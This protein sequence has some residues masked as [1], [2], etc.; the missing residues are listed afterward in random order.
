MVLREAEVVYRGRRV[1]GPG[2]VRCAA[3]VARIC[4]DVEAATV[5]RFMVLHLNQRHAVVARHVVSQGSLGCVEVHPREV[6]RAAI[7]AGAAA[8][9]LVHNHPSGDCAPSPEDWSVTKRICAAGELLGIRVLDHVVIG[10]GS[11]TSLAELDPGLF[12][13]R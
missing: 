9:I 3:D 4:R 8:V 6:F 11:H 10:D 5:E 7:M 1:P 13:A 2:F 12:A